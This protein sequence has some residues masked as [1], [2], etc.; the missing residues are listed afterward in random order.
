MIFWDSR[1]SR[2]FLPILKFCSTG[3]RDRLFSKSKDPNFGPKELGTIVERDSGLTC[4]LMK[5]VNS[6]A[7]GLRTK[8]SS[9]KQAIALL[10]VKQTRNFLLTT[11]VKKT[12][13]SSPSKL[14]NFRSFWTQ[15][16]ERGLFA[17][18][19]ARLL[20]TDADLAYSGAMLQDFLFLF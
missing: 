13:Q 14:I 7:I 6:S 10:G 2:S 4:E 19:V 8:A 9:A 1:R 18:K 20:G 5:L 17:S 3:R 12:M 15:N 16:L 11:G